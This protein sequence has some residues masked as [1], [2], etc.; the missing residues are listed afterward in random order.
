[1]TKQQ[2]ELNEIIL[3]FSETNGRLPYQYELCE[4]TGKPAKA[5]SKI[6]TTLGLNY[7]EELLISPYVKN[8]YDNFEDGMTLQQLAN[9]VGV[10]YNV[11]YNYLYALESM[12]CKFKLK[13]NRDYSFLPRIDK[14]KR[15]RGTK[16]KEERV[17]SVRMRYEPYKGMLGYLDNDLNVVLHIKGEKKIIKCDTYEWEEI[18]WEQSSIILNASNGFTK[19][20]NGTTL[21][22]S[23]KLWKRSVVYD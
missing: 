2:A 3:A 5:I 20:E 16:G 10:K 9:K 11:A 4:I 13:T 17:V 15:N 1:M 14:R 23:L 22:R 7:P 21:G 6:I 19:T 18:K 8:L 12:G